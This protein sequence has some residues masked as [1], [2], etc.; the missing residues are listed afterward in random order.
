MTC[1]NS[2][3]RGSVLVEMAI[4]LPVLLLLIL[5]GIDLDLMVTS[6]SALNYV[7]SETARCAAHNPGCVPSAFA[8]VTATGLGLKGALSISASPNCPPPTGS[9][10][11]A[12]VTAS[13]SWSPLS[14]FFRPVTLTSTATAQQ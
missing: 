1:D 3:Q 2:K 4:V 9:P 12:T 10:C 13:Y 7:A 14:P 6:K 5:G 11:T 8:Q